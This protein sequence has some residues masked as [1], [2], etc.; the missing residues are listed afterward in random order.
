MHVSERITIWICATSVA[1][2]TLH[3]IEKAIVLGVAVYV[4]SVSPV[5]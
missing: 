5:Q 2:M 3:L 4:N 1:L